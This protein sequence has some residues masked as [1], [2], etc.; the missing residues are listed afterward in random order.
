MP[1]YTF[2]HCKPDGSAGSF[3]TAQLPD[4]VSAGV[5]ARAILDEHLSCAYVTVWAGEE[6]LEERHR[7][8]LPLAEPGPSVVF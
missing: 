1:L 3:E 7:S 6:K 8:T 2:Y 4:D 5:R